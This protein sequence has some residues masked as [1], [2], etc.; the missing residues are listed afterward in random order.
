MF[1]GSMM[2]I[3]VYWCFDFM[4]STISQTQTVFTRI[5]TQHFATDLVLFFRNLIIND[6]RKVTINHHATGGLIQNH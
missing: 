1:S 5:G 6:N 2:N 4:C 3:Q